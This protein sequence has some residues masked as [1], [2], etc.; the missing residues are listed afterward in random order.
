LCLLAI[1]VLGGC[2]GGGPK[3]DPDQ[4]S[5]V[6]R[7]AAKAIADRDGAKACGYLT[8]E[9]QQQVVTIAGSAFGGADCPSIVKLATATLAPLDRT[10]IDDAQPQNIVVTGTSATAEIVIPSANNQ[11]PPVSL[12][13][14]KTADGWRIASLS[15][16][17]A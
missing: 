10:Q 13:L 1:A 6:L 9:G 5:Q 17:P 4:I 15:R 14:Q 8:P 3:S 11:N 12:A 7:D 16:L 2:G